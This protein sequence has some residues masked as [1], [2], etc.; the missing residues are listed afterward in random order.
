MVNRI[1]NGKVYV[2]ITYTLYPVI[3]SIAQVMPVTCVVC[4]LYSMQ[5]YV[6]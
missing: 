6:K 1:Q 2:G 5:N 3:L 4:T